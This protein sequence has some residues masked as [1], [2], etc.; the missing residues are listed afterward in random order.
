L[1]DIVVRIGELGLGYRFEVL[2]FRGREK[3]KEWMKV[4]IMWLR[5]KKREIFSLGPACFW[6]RKKYVGNNNKKQ[7]II[8]FLPLY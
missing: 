2:G 6:L 3:K 1:K 8:F 5:V 4:E 7:L